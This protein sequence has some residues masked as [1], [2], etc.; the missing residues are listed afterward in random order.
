ME[1]ELK[2]YTVSSAYLN[3][4]KDHQKHMWDNEEK[5]RL[6]P[7]IGILITINDFKYYAPLSSPKPKHAGWKDRL[8]FIRID[9]KGE[10]KCVVN[11]NNIIPVHDDDIFL[12]DIDK[13]E[14]KYANLLNVE[15][16]EIRKKKA[17]IINNAK[18]LYEKI[19][20][21]KADN[22]KLA[23]FCYNF[24]L[25]EEKLK[26]YIIIK[27]KERDALADKLGQAFLNKT[28]EE[29]GASLDNIG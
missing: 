28:L 4:L 22:A 5:G 19:T 1:T 7:Y 8:D 24:N 17:I 27:Q 29:T 21:H 26:H 20:K 12:I 3:Y 16:I 18:S 10:L 13:E 11:L 14:E 23:L 15:M 2:L 25:L 6:R 9:Y